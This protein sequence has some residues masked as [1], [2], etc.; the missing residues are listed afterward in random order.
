MTFDIQPDLIGT[1]FVRCDFL[2]GFR[3]DIFQSCRWRTGRV[4]TAAAFLGIVNVNI[5]AIR[6]RYRFFGR[7]IVVIIQYGI[8]CPYAVG[9]L[10]DDRSLHY[11]LVTG[12]IFI[13]CASEVIPIDIH[14]K[15]YGR[16]SVVD[17]CRRVDFFNPVFCCGNPV[18]RCALLAIVPRDSVSREAVNFKLGVDLLDRFLRRLDLYR[19]FNPLI[20][21]VRDDRNLI[22]DVG[23]LN[24][25]DYLRVNTVERRLLGGYLHRNRAIR[26][27]FFACGVHE[28]DI[29][30]KDAVIGLSV[31]GKSLLGPLE[32]FLVRLLVELPDDEVDFL[33]ESICRRSHLNGD[34]IQLCAV[35]DRFC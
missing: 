20:G 6:D 11:F 32:L 2:I 12:R 14:S 34:R 13:R 27:D 10:L 22:G 8:Y 33:V 9:V 21:A 5:A 26:L 16:G 15:I 29:K 30:D 31:L 18:D 4:I 28:V 23:H 25:V 3:R 7:V 1:V 24:R 17:R 35:H 19:S